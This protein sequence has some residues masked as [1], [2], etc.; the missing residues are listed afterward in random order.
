MLQ[1][2]RLGNGFIVAQHFNLINFPVYYLPRQS[3]NRY[4]SLLLMTQHLNYAMSLLLT[5][6]I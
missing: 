5:V 4:M 2:G 1:P 6:P 3:L